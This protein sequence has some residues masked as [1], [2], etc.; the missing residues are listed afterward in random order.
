MVRKLRVPSFMDC[1]NCSLSV[2]M[3][4]DDAEIAGE[5]RDGIRQKLSK[6]LARIWTPKCVEGCTNYDL[7]QV[8]AP[9]V[10]QEFKDTEASLQD[11]AAR[12]EHAN[13]ERIL[14]EGNPFVE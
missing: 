4:L 5:A 10:I 2:D 3:R 12:A 8:E 14:R 6:E 11:L 7:V 1:S 9:L 13:R